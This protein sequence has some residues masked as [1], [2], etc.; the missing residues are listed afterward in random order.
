MIDNQIGLEKNDRAI[1]EMVPEEYSHEERSETYEGCVRSCGNCCGIFKTWICCC[2]QTPYFGIAEW[3]FGIIQEFGKFTKILPPGLHYV[4][5][6]SE[7]LLLIDRREQVIDLK[8]QS[9]MTKD[10]VNVTIDAVVYYH[11]E[12]AYKAAFHVEDCRFAIIEIAKTSMRDVFG[13]TLLQESL[14][15]KDKMAAHVRELIDRPTHNWGITITRVLIQEIIF[16][17]EL[18]RNLSSAATAK[19]TAEAKIISAQADVSAAKLMRESSDILNTPAAMQI[20]FLDSITALARSGNT[21]V[22]V[23]PNEG[24][25]GSSDPKTLKKYL[26]QNEIN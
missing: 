26:V 24:P 3:N 7:T 22:I 5:P 25:D 21:K 11:V 9:I 2:C 6:F 23:M 16:T 15:G 12:D 8:K 4:N 10:N 13:H 18:Q 1:F 19:R 20:R 17:P 14:E